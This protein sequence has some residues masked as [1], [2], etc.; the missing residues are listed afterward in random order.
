MHARCLRVAWD[1]PPGRMVRLQRRRDDK[2]RWEEIGL[3]AASPYLD[4]QVH[5]VKATC[6]RA[7]LVGDLE[8]DWS[9]TVCA[10]PR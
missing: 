4:E 10:S 2:D 8:G 7:K 3:L 9:A 1:A 6:Y 5:P